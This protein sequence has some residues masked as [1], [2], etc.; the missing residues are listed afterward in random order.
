[1]GPAAGFAQIPS[2]ETIHVVSD[3]NYPPFIFKDNEGK[4]QGILVDEWRLWEHKTGIKVDLHAMD[5]GAAL[6]R[7]HAGEFDVI[8]TI[9]DTED[10]RTWLDFS[11]PYARIEVPI[12]FRKDISGITDL[13]S[14][15][16]FAV[17]VKSGD[18]AE[19]LL[20]QNGVFDVMR[21]ANYESI[22]TAAKQRKVNVFVVDKPPAVYFLNKLEI[23]D[24]FH[25]SAPVNVGEFH[26]AVRKGNAALLQQVQAGFDAITPDE[27]KRIEDKWY[28][29]TIAG[30]INLRYLGY[31]AG[32]LL[33]LV[34]G[35]LAWSAALR[36]EVKRRTA[37]L[38]ESEERLRSLGDNLPNGVVYQ[39]IR[40]RD[41]THRFI[42]M[43]AGVERLNGLTA[44]AV[45]HD[46]EAAYRQILPEDL[47]KVR[48]AEA[49]SYANLSVF[50]V[51]ARIHN[52]RGE[53]RWVQ[54]CSAP[55][56]LPD[57]R[58]LWDG[59][60]LD[61]TERK[62]AEM[63]I[64][65]LNRVYAMLSDINQTIVRE[66]A[67]PAL[68]TAACRI[69]VEKGGF[70][71]AWI[72]M[73]DPHTQN[74]ELVA[75]IGA[76]ADTLAILRQHMLT[77]EAHCYGCAF[78]TRAL[79]TGEPAVCNDIANDPQAAS[80]RQVA[81]DRNYRAMASLP[82]RTGSQIVGIFNLYAGEAG[83]FDAEE[84]RL[85][86][87]L[88]ADI[89]F[90]LEVQQ[91]EARQLQAEAALRSSEERFRQLAETIQEVFW[92]TEPAS[93]RMIYI[94]PAY[95]TVWGRT[96]E[97]LYAAPGSWL[98]AVHPED[99]ERVQVAAKTKQAAGLYDEE[100]RIIRPDKT[101]R[102]VR[103][104][105]FPLYNAAG[106]VDRMIGVARDITERRKLEEQLRQAQKM[107]AIGQL[108][109]GVAHDFNNIL[110]VIQ[111]QAGLL[112][113]SPGILPEHAEFAAEIEAAAQRAANLTRQLLV[114][115]RRQTMQ[116][117]DLNLNDVVKQIARMLQRVIHEDIKLE[118][119][120]ATEPLWVRADGGMMDQVLLNLTVNARDAMPR[121]GTLL[122]ET[123]AVELDELAARQ[124]PAAR[125]GKYIR[126]TVS[127][128]GTGI[129]PDILPHIFE[130]FFTTKD[131]G[132][133]TGIGLA[134][135]QGI[136]LQHQGWVNVSSEA[137]QGTTFRIY[138]PRLLKLSAAAETAANPEAVPSGNE[139]IL[140]AEDDAK[141]R[142]SVR[143]AL[144]RLGYRVLEAASGAEALGLWEQ[145]RED[146]QLLLVDLVMPGGVS[147]LELAQNI[148]RHRAGMKV[149]YTTGHSGEIAGP[150][151]SL[152][153]GVNFLIKPF[154]THKLAVTVRRMLDSISPT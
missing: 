31:A 48:A 63:H 154:S 20:Q 113:K 67:A 111:M 138:L 121:G 145:N 52:A 33:V 126:L 136:I 108:A 8:D 53:L 112:E 84:M 40:E 72:G 100:Y 105:A 4:L 127:D 61:V 134:T 78:T 6:R 109:G 88:A 51:E 144:T 18:A 27:L 70:A 80:W 133:G 107:E 139:T 79:Q 28:G 21:F 149:I 81:L 66:K 60:S 85:L 30:G 25:Y 23:E 82:L 96:C 102:W 43:S 16:G 151:P 17:A 98:D 74:I 118:F 104:Q 11:R 73:V 36:R 87:E 2:G 128:T 41:G 19:E 26:R 131:I 124:S 15:R 14:L 148:C 99:R 115:S 97:S 77:N 47:E 143:A 146:I 9:F 55:R 35:L 120:L 103:D 59:I 22:I 7:M 152:E 89:S 129:S 83:F 94:S 32:T 54:L 1:L 58:V 119:K 75:S 95:L 34:L 49:A 147:G 57:G 153:E 140:L 5:W 69:A 142:A 106:E 91:R 117:E 76:T 37:A 45:L 132:K 44:A 64:R 86:D 50:N 150:N 10:R 116:L 93:G 122:I 92:I 42:Y 137:G 62:Q 24:E 123:D 125:P 110:A 141:L 101:V 56:R 12:Y 90:A 39:M 114:F 46:P 13:K 3:D 130:P 68:L 38:R 135:V 65:H 71:M 29:K